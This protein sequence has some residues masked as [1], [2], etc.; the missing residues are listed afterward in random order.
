MT[1]QMVYRR[2][3]IVPDAGLDIEDDG[4]RTG[5]GSFRVSGKKPR[6]DRGFRTV[7]KTQ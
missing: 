6:V 1:T 5:V 2:L 4:T 3:E 7:W